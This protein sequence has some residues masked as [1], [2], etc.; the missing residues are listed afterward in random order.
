MEVNILLIIAGLILLCNVV[1]GYK[2]GMVKSI[3]SL[4][5]LII[6]CVIVALIGN[7]LRKY[8]N[9][10]YASLVVIVLLLC[11]VAIANHMLSV[12]LFSAKLISK[13]PVI[14]SV[15]KLLGIVFGILKTVFF[16]W[17][18]YTLASIFELG[19]FETYITQYTNN[20]QIL[21]WFYENNYLAQGL[22]KLGILD[23]IN[24]KM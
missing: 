24:S 2:K 18:I 8:T 4:I 3:V 9:G 5:S 21:M 22:E 15:D 16:V 1:D 12:V 6:L 19:K 7:G 13:L 17:T 10:D 11:I 14:H 23:F 20:S